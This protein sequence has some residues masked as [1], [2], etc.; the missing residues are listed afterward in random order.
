MGT[1]QFTFRTPGNPLVQALWMVAGIALLVA[2]VI[3]GALV[4]TV[5]L[6]LGVIA[7][8]VFAA[9][10]W[11]L[12][13]KLARE[14]AFGASPERPGEGPAERHEPRLI[15][16]EYTVVSER[17]VPEAGEREARERANRRA[18]R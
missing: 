5:L 18:S 8:A 14:G 15:D 12:K 1:R 7:A 6:A 17:D 4:L 11:W 2:A 13:R 16:A 3:M 9:R 10:V